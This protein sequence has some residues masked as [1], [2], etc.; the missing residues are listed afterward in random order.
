MAELTPQEIVR[1]W[2]DEA[3]YNSLT[4]EQRA[5]VPPSPSMLSELSENELE[6]V[7]GGVESCERDSCTGTCKRKSEI[8]KD[9]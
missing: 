4:P 7:A 3:F 2:R 1:A 6:S 5:A 8:I 9:A